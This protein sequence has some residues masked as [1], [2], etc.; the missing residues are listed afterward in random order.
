MSLPANEFPHRR[1]SQRMNVLVT[2]ENRF[3]DVDGA[4]YTSTIAPTFFHRYLDVWD[5]VLLL[6]RVSRADSPPPGLLPIDAR[7]V[8]SLNCPISSDRCNT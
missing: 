6:A 1:Y 5:E 8:P 3:V 2:S 7:G 4:M